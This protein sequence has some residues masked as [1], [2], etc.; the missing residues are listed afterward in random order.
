MGG[1]LPLDDHT[2][3]PRYLSVSSSWHDVTIVRFVKHTATVFRFLDKVVEDLDN[4][5]ET[6]DMFR[7]VTK[8][9]AVQGLGVKDF[10]IIKGIGP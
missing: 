6:I 5:K 8:I 4:P 7:R 2:E 9:H 3:L 1:H 10:V